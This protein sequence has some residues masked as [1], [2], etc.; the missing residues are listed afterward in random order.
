MTGQALGAPN[1]S[2]QSVHEGGN[3]V[4]PTHQS[5]LMP[6]RYPWYLFSVRVWVD[7]RAIVPPEG[8]S[9]WKIPVTPPGIEPAIA[10]CSTKPQPTVPTR[11]S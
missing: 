2:R 3:V 10:A 4:S 8:L 1:I 7:R 9:Q 11:P 5:P 6:R